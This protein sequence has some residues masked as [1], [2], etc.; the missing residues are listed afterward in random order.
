MHASTGDLGGFF[1]MLSMYLVASFT[2]AYAAERFFGLRTW[3]FVVIFSVLL[4]FCIWADGQPYHII[5]D[6]FGDTVFLFLV[7][8]TVIIELLNSYVRKVQHSK[9]WV[10]AAFAALISA[11]IIWNLTQTGTSLCDPQSPLQ[12]HA[13]WHILDAVSAFCL[14]R[15]YASEHTDRAQ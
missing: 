2:V 15:Y 4:A 8:I 10:F 14:F 5:F 9:T 13:A 7:S 12:G 3:H 6:F 11:F 1:D